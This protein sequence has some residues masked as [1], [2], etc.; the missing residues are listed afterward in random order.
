MVSAADQADPP[1]ERSPQEWSGRRRGGRLQSHPGDL[2][3]RDGC[4][5]A[6][7][8]GDDPEIA[9]ACPEERLRHRDG[10]PSGTRRGFEQPG[11]D[12][13]PDLA[14]VCLDDPD[15]LPAAAVECDRSTDR[16]LPDAASGVE[17]GRVA[18]GWLQDPV[19]DPCLPSAAEGQRSGDPVWAPECGREQSVGERDDQVFPGAVPAA[20]GRQCELCA[21][22][23]GGC[24]GP[25][26][27]QPGVVCLY[28][29]GDAALIDLGGDCAAGVDALELWLD[30]DLGVWQARDGATVSATP[31]Q[32]LIDQQLAAAAAWTDHCGDGGQAECA[33]SDCQSG[34]AVCDDAAALSAGGQMDLES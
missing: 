26:R 11:L 21:L 1:S 7:S 17:G 14:C 25:G 13:Q 34:L 8:T 30:G 23:A 3:G 2:D 28:R 24:V 10:Q 29:V 18:T 32:F 27:E 12:P 16:L 5:F 19:G 22:P 15:C 6:T 9:T 31:G 4:G 20:D 33:L